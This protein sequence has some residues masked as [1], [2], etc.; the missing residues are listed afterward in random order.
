MS[1]NHHTPYIDGTTDFKAVDMNAPI[2]KLDQAITDLQAQ[3]LHF[4][5]DGKPGDGQVLLRVKFRRAFTIPAGLTLSGLD[6]LVAATAEAVCSVKKDGTEFG[7]MTFAASGT[8]T[9][10]AAALETVFAIG[11]IL[12]VI[13]PVTADATLADLFGTIVGS[14]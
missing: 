2:A 11:D 10:Q 14:R 7:T 1:T 5:R 4:M 8:I 9:T 6:A 13:A 12:T 3:D